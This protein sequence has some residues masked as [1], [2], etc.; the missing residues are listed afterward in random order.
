MNRV[1]T[2]AWKEEGEWRGVVHRLV[3]TH[4]AT[5]TLQF[6]NMHGEKDCTYSNSQNANILS[7]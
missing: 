1:V 3:W 2:P 7:C 6:D 4:Q 5:T